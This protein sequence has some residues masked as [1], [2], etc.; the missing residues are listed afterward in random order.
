[1]HLLNERII[2]PVVLLNCYF[3][4]R[5]KNSKIKESY[6]KC[7]IMRHHFI[8]HFDNLINLFELGSLVVCVMEIGN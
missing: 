8:W 2:M 1:M 7:H 5:E 3:A 6:W 4:K